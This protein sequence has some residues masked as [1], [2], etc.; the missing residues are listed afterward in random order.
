[1]KSRIMFHLARTQGNFSREGVKTWVNMMMCVKNN[2][3]G[4]KSNEA[5][6]RNPTQ[7]EDGM[8]E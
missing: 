1:M 8:G 7:E 3:K 2:K 5:E 4:N 6:R